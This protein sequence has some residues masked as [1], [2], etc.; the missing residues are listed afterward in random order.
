MI[1]VKSITDPSFKQYARVIRDVDTSTLMEALKQTPAPE[2]RVVYEP[3][4]K[5]LEDLPIYEVIR[6]KLYGG[7]PV[8]MGYCNGENYALDALEYHRDS[9][10]NFACTDAILLIG[11]QQDI[12]YDAYSYDTANVEAYLVPAGTLL[13][14]YATTLH[15]APVSPG[16]GQTF[17]FLVA[18]PKGTNYDLTYAPD[19]SGEGKMHFAVNKWLIAHPDSGLGDQG[20]HVGLV[21][22]NHRLHQ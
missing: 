11:R 21:G 15:Y 22:V 16:P 1:Q 3:S 4:V 2:G 10:I 12:D 14:V 18:L 19:R 20:A 17:R 7:M 9:E 8:Q 5:A 6:D 13:D